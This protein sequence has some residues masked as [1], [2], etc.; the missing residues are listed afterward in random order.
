MKDAGAPGVTARRG[1][2]C[3][4]HVRVERLTWRDPLEAFAPFADEPFALL[5]LSAGGPAAGWSYVARTPD[6][7]DLVMAADLDR[8]FGR[9]RQALGWRVPR[10]ASGPPFQGGV[11]GLVAYEF[12]DRLEPFGLARDPDWPDLV[13]A[14]FHAILAFDHA[15]RTLL[16]V[17]RGASPRASVEA[18][19]RAGQWLERAPPPA[20]LFTPA[21][22]FT[23]DT[24]AKAYE[25]AVREDEGLKRELVASA[26]DRA[27]NLMIV[28]LMRND[29]ARV[30]EA[31]SIRAPELFA[32]E[33]YAAVHH[34]VSTITGRLR[35]ECDAADLLG[36]SFPPGSITGT[37]KIQSMKVIAGR[38]GPRGP[39]CGSLFWAGSDGAFDSSV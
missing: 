39:W 29:L 2:L 8:D 21:A 7:T 3:A 26:K 25:T 13:L 24:S 12:A 38:E 18:A 20:P 37:P 33:S 10:E 1:P 4:P 14:R 17:G 15:S 28:D 22:A 30:C 6:L 31:G 11:V 5:L 9:L 27:E 35:A 32:V 34:L 23:A 19:A 16:A 36:A